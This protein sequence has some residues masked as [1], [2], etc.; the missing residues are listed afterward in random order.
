MAITTQITNEEIDAVEAGMIEL[1]FSTEEGGAN[2][3]DEQ[4]Q[5]RYQVLAAL[6]GRLSAMR[7]SA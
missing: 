4:A 3:G 5:Q 7:T 6:H 2:E 1:G